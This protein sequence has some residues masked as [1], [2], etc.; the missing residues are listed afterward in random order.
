ML[1]ALARLWGVTLDDTFLSTV[2]RRLGAD[3]PYFVIGGTA[4]GIGRG[5]LVSPLADLPDHT[6]LILRPSFGVGTADAYRWVA[7]ARA[8]AGHTHA[9]GG[10]RQPSGWPETSGE[11]PARLGECRNDFEPVVAARFPVVGDLTAALR[12][13]GA[14]LA[15]LSGSGS[16]V[17]GLFDNPSTAETARLAFDGRPGLGLRV[18]R[19]VSRDEYLAEVAPVAIAS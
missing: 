13:R 4:L 1:R 14:S 17:V 18:S 6:V 9:G 5:D 19:T 16:A 10:E 8:G 15:V 11:W 3:V 2:A 12:A 7:E